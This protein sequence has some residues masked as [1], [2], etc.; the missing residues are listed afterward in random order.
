MM[1]M[2]K[3][4]RK[5]ELSENLIKSFCMKSGKLRERGKNKAV[6]KKGYLLVNRKDRGETCVCRHEKN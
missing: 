6:Y 2:I 1:V 4:R 5:K 3:E